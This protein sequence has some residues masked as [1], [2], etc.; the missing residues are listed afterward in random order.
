MHRRPGMCA[1]THTQN[2]LEHESM[3]QCQVLLENVN[4]FLA[5]KQDSCWLTVRPNLCRNQSNTE[6][7]FIYVINC[8]STPTQKVQPYGK[9]FYSSIVSWGPF[10]CYY[11]VSK[12][13]KQLAT[14]GLIWPLC[15]ISLAKKTVFSWTHNALDCLLFSP[16]KTHLK[17]REIQLFGLF[18]IFR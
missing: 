1:H 6:Q 3:L 13:S 16:R 12:T 15:L 14:N 10:T 2:S 8:G 7:C 17:L 4:E 11:S 9:S 5:L 18:S